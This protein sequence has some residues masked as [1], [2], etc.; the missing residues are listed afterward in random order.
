MLLLLVSVVLS[1]RFGSVQIAISEVYRVLLNR[2]SGGYFFHEQTWSP[3]T[4][5]IVWSIRFP[6]VIVTAFAGAIFALS[7]IYMQTLTQ[8]PVAEPYVLGISS[9]A[10]AGAVFAIIFGFSTA[11]GG[12]AV[13]T[14]AFL[15]A[16]IALSLVLTLAGRHPS[17]LRL[18]LLGLGISAF[19]SALT[20][21]TLNE[22]Q[23]DS[24]LRSA[25]FWMLGSFSA[26][27]WEDIPIISVSF[28]I[29]LAMGLIL[30][31]ELDALLLGDSTAASLGV[32]VKPVKRIIALVSAVIVSIVIS[33]TGVI[34][35]V[36]LI[37]PHV[38]RRI[39]GV[40][41]KRLIPVAALLGAS[42]MVGA[43]SLA[44]TLFS[45][46]EI[47]VGIITSLMG[48]PLFIWIVQRDYSFGGQ[49]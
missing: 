19:F 13:Q 5:L 24:Q 34:G 20:T 33:R 15:G 38:A 40:S 32:S 22:A 48:A 17:P 8:N 16:L 18:I 7:G 11:L 23:N 49:S 25:V 41:H 2:L 46:E 45:P 14:A 47:P 27:R 6:R 31:K 4:E 1:V 10:S 21:F 35:F 26:V 9:G 30:E 36:G 42:F 43:D 29:A 3:S 37:V 28:L 44:R 39:V 12:Y